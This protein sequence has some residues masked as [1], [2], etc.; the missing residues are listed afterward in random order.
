M[1]KFLSK[2]EFF[3]YFVL[4]ILSLIAFWVRHSTMWLV[5]CFGWLSMG[6]IH[7]ASR[8]KKREK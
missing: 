6:F 1:K 2:H 5:L 8:K 3:L 4:A 7:M